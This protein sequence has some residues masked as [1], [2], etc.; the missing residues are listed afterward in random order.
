MKDSLHLGVFECHFKAI[1]VRFSIVNYYGHSVFARDL[2]LAHEHLALT[3]AVRV[4]VV[5]VKSYLAKGNDG[6][7]ISVFNLG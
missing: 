7:A 2:V 5:I 1:T 3:S 4:L 6:K